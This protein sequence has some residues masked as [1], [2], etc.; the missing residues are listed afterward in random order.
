MDAIVFSNLLKMHEEWLVNR[1]LHYAKKHGYSAYTSTLMNAWKISIHKL[2]QTISETYELYGGKLPELSSE[3]AYQDDPCCAFGV[4]EARRHRERGISIAMFLGL[5]KY[6]RQ[7]YCDLVTEKLS[8]DSK[9]AALTDFTIRFYDRLELAM[10]TEWIGLGQEKSVLELQAK[11]RD[12]T[13]EKNK[14]LTLFESLAMPVILIDEDLCLDNLNMAAC[15]MLGM[16]S[17]CAAGDSTEQENCQQAPRPDNTSLKSSLYWLWADVQSFS[18]S[19][20]DATTLQRSF[21]QDSVT[22]HYEATLAR[23]QDVSGKFNGII[24]M[25]KDITDREHLYQKISKAYDHLEMRVEEQA[26]ELMQT[27][28]HLVQEMAERKQAEKALREARLRYK[29]LVD[30]LH[31][32]IWLLDTE[33][34]TVFVNPRMANMLG[35]KVNDMVGRKVFDFIHPD[36]L[37]TVKTNLI[38]RRNGLVQGYEVTLVH[39]DGMSL[40]VFSS[41]TPLKDTDGNYTGSLAG[42]MDMTPH[43]QMEEALRAAMARAQEANR[44]KS[45]FLANM[46]HEIRTPLNGVLGMLQLLNMTHLDM[47][48]SEY[49]NVAFSSGRNLLTLI[50]DILD[51]SRVESGRMEIRQEVC[52][53][54]DVI[55]QTADTF[56]ESAKL[57][58]IQ[59]TSEVVGL[60]KVRTDPRRL[61]QILFNLLGNAVKFTK[62][63]KIEIQA[64][65]I[66]RSGQDVTVLFSVQD[67]GIG[68]GEEMLERIFHPFTQGDGSTTRKYQGTGLGLHIVKRLVHLMGGT[69]SVESEPD[70]GTTIYFTIKMQDAQEAPKPSCI[71][72]SP[73][74]PQKVNQQWRILVVE[75]NPINST[76]AI[77]MLQILGFEA[78]AVEDGSHVLSAL[79]QGSY[80]CVLMDV[81]MP[82]MNGLD[83]TR[84]V[85]T[86]APPDIRDIP[87]V[88]M[89]AHAM[90]GDREIC[91]AAGMDEYLSKPLDM[92]LM[93]KMLREV[94]Q[95][96]QQKQTP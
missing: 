31:E 58:G 96:P 90:K 65:P 80:D 21:L 13:N 52:K 22:L 60:E 95:L 74:P 54:S 3:D 1:V 45:E 36:D 91:I 14:Y 43:K 88:A 81:Q 93:E 44:A 34:R 25:L 79:Q 55:L 33:D 4:K 6:C 41:A 48:Q 38:L 57:K 24:L 35:Y 61:R 46:S 40:P 92:R 62:Q 69:L 86:E 78:D 39:K 49:V 47:E 26:S 77:R 27:S 10:C 5:L 23:M 75:D 51:L 19:G 12:M 73:T 16:Q 37:E 64:S 42:V 17:S 84:A 29:M 59:I 9:A 7:T 66:Q 20:E 15:R 70:Q 18:A 8:V 50:N 67:T 11:N 71:P 82:V 32:G 63:G 89:T 72:Q 2:S 94:L 53:I 87:I 68:I 85:R 28:A 30:N 56:R 83:A 76:T